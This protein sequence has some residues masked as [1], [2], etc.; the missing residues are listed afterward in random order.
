MLLLVLAASLAAQDGYA[1][2]RTKFKGNDALSNGKLRAAV[3]MKGM[4]VWRVL[5]FWKGPQ[6]Y[7]PEMLDD[8]RQSLLRLYQ[9]EGFLDVS[10]EPLVQVNHQR[11]KVRV[12]YMIWENRPIDVGEVRYSI[13]LPGEAL[14]DTLMQRLRHKSNLR[15]G[16]RFRDASVTA[17]RKHISQRLAE[18]AFPFPTIQRNLDVRLSTYTADVDWHISP[19]PRCRLGHTHVTGAPFNTEGYVRSRIAYSEGD[20]YTPQ[21]LRRTQNAIYALGVFE[22]VGVRAPRD[23]LRGDRLPVLIDL[24]PMP[25]KHLRTGVGWGTEERFRAFA[26]YRLLHLFHGVERLD[27]S[28]RHSWL[29]PWSLSATLT[30]PALLYSRTALSVSPFVRRQRETAWTLDRYGAEA[31]LRRP[32]S[33]SIRLTLSYKF[34]RNEL[35][36]SSLSASE[37][38]EATDN[39]LYNKST[40]GLNLDIDTATPSQDPSAG[41]HTGA[42]VSY[43]GPGSSYPLAS[44]VFEARR[45]QGIARGLVLALKAKGGVIHTLQGNHVVPVEERFYAG[46]SRSVRGWKRSSLGPEDDDGNPAGGLSLL[47]GSAELRYPIWNKFSGVVFVDAGNVWTQARHYPLS[48]LRYAGGVGLRYNSPVGPARIDVATPIDQP[49]HPVQV[50]ISIGHAF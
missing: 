12:T 43:S 10:I 48:E 40:L 8:D 29:E 15:T 33:A 45:Y 31:S 7:D 6:H 19:G 49:A 25:R 38:E 34:E 20:W 13:D 41:W 50:H 22:A 1:L 21:A 16:S 37:I 30:H 36:E 35:R 32:L 18:T 3:Q 24:T 26:S 47:E 5:L 11:K 28:A 44:V 4:T 39:T 23:S 14:R 2:Q 42:I 17:E 9:K 27:V 46:G